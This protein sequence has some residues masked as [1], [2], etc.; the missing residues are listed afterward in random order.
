ME[1][2]GLAFGFTPSLLEFVSMFGVIIIGN[3]FTFED[4]YIYI[5][6]CNI[7]IY[8]HVHFC[9]YICT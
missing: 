3:R 6:T 9:M 7:Y 8:V 5:Y 2:S 4:V 1:V